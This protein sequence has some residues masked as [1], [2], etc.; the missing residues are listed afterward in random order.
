MLEFIILMVVLDLLMRW[1]VGTKEIVQE[2]PTEDKW[3]FIDVDDVMEY[4][5]LRA[6]GW[7]GNAADFYK[8]KEAE[9]I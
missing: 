4:R 5:E 1:Q 2:E 8:W 3:N 9:E 7:K 6:S